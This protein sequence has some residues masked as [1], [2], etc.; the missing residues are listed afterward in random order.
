MEMKFAEIMQ[1][2]LSL[3]KNF[4]MIS[5]LKHTGYEATTYHQFL[6]VLKATV[7]PE[8]CSPQ[9]E[10]PLTLSVLVSSKIF[11]GLKDFL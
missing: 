11:V 9:I 7:M 2:W 6:I 1:D 4:L 8:S 3:Q 5:D 10:N